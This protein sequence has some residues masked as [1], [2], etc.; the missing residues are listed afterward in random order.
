MACWSAAVS[1]L[2]VGA[3]AVCPRG[4]CSVPAIDR[5]ILD[6]LHSLRTPAL[7][8]FFA[9]VTWLGSMFVLLPVASV[10]AAWLWRRGRQR[11]AGVIALS[12]GGAW[13]LAH[14]AKAVIARPRPELHEAL[15][16]MPEDLSFPS[17]HTLQATAFALA[18]ALAFRQGWLWPVT[19][20]VVALV[21]LSR[22]WL[23]VHFPS[24]V[25]FGFAAALC[26]TLGA[27]VLLEATP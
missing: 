2:W 24:D 1:L 21:A 17:A 8:A 14:A 26:W 22:L 27:H 15:V 9:G 3:V 19:A 16:A 12:L 4:N 13:L 7:D 11:S 5:T 6:V 25:V 23:Q 18:V 10:L 20:L